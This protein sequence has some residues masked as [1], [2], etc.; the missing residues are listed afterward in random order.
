MESGGPL[1]L[2]LGEG[3]VLREKFKFICKTGKIKVRDGWE[4]ESG[5]WQWNSKKRGD[6][7]EKQEIESGY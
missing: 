7:Q 5:K 1:L 4:N 2:L 6:A 3:V